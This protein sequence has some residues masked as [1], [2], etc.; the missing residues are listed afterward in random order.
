MKKDRTQRPTE[1]TSRRAQELEDL[2]GVSEPPKS[3][4]YAIDMRIACPVSR[5]GLKAYVGDVHRSCHRFRLCR[6]A[7]LRAQA[8]EVLTIVARCRH[9]RWGPDVVTAGV[10]DCSNV[11]PAS[12][13]GSAREDCPP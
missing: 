7:G 5:A 2:D 6:V 13:S 12:A 4:N 10:G 11:Q 3:L 1:K 9:R 8:V